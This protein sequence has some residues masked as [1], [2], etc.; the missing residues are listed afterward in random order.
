MIV[1]S[2][3]HKRL[4][5]GSYGARP[6]RTSTDP[7]FLSTLQIEMAHLSRT[8]LVNIPN[9]ATQCYDRIVSNLAMVSCILHYMPPSAAKCIGSTLRQARYHLKTSL[10]ETTNYWQH[11]QDT[12]I[13]GTGQGSGISPGICCVLFSDLFH[14]HSQI[15]PISH[16]EC[17]TR[18]IH[19]TIDNVGFVN[20]TTTT[21]NDLCSNP[22]VSPVQLLLN[23]QQTLQNWNDYIYISGGNL[24]LRKTN[25]F[26]LLWTFASSGHPYLADHSQ[27]SITI[28]NYSRT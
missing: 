21:T 10:A 6:G 1:S 15:S 26:Q 23:G 25:V 13:Y 16:Y 14:C 9:D 7:P 20:N 17:P 5:P 11:S 27:Q 28:Q 4:H 22:P 19:S 12:P 2:E 24:E 18:R 8:S 3:K